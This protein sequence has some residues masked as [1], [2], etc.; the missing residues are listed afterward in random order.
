MKDYETPIGIV[1]LEKV[2]VLTDGEDF[3]NSNLDIDGR[4]TKAGDTFYS[5][6]IAGG[7]AVLG[8]TENQ[9]IA[10]AMAGECLGWVNDNLGD[11]NFSDPTISEKSD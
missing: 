10:K 2:S 6:H 5:A 11:I 4:L 3:I 9:A 1:S 7:C 8:W